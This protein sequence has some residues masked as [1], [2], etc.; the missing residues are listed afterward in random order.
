MR[1]RRP[2]T[3]AARPSS[4]CWQSKAP[5]VEGHIPESGL[6]GELWL[7]GGCKKI[8]GTQ[9]AECRAR[10]HCF[11]S[12]TIMSL[13]QK[14]SYRWVSGA[15]RTRS[16]ASMASLETSGRTGLRTIGAGG[17]VRT[18]EPEDF[19][20]PPDLASPA[21]LVSD[22]AGSSQNMASKESK[23]RPPTRSRAPRRRPCRLTSGGKDVG[24][25][26]AL[27]GT[28][29]AVRGT[30]AIASSSSSSSGSGD[31]KDKLCMIEVQ[32][33]RTTAAL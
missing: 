4:A 33:V 19:A 9:T 24:R 32:E 13:P 25:E 22:D 21:A 18:I 10:G 28:S 11:A 31:A 3:P 30:A 27:R 5:Y 15:S 2:C 7:A 14:M 26:G 23:S 8:R 1:H 20:A 6:G 29:A 16:I 12:C 17:V